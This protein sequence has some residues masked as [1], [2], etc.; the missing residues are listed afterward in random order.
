MD[1]CGRSSW[2]A[3]GR[4]TPAAKPLLG[5]LTLTGRSTEQLSRVHKD[6]ETDCYSSSAIRRIIDLTEAA[7]AK[8]T[9]QRPLALHLGLCSLV[10]EPCPEKAI[11]A[12]EA[13]PRS[14]RPVPRSHRRTV[15]SP[16]MCCLGRSAA[17]HRA[18]S[19]QPGGSLKRKTFAFPSDALYDHR[20]A[21]EQSTPAKRSPDIFRHWSATSEI[22][23]ALREGCRDCRPSAT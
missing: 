9:H 1:G 10:D 19:R 20:A 5:R 13:P 11:L 8:Q 12:R 16:A 18:R 6:P 22:H 7:L 3:S 23:L 15:I 4:P 17:T 2:S 14:P 21:Y